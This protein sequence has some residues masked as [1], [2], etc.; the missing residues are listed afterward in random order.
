MDNARHL[1]PWMSLDAVNR[2]LKKLKD[3][4]TYGIIDEIIEKV[5]VESKLAVDEPSFT[6]SKETVRSRVKRNDKLTKS[7]KGPSPLLGDI[8]PFLVEICKQKARM[9]QP[10]GMTE[11]L[12]MANSIIDG[13]DHHER[14]VNFKKGLRLSGDG[15]E[16]LGT[17]SWR[18]FRKRNKGVRCR[19][20]RHASNKLQR[21]EHLPKEIEDV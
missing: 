4:V 19:Y 15:L 21:V 10:M 5:L 18:L 20:G 16:K 9:G 14:M 17:C 12:A 2:Q 8:E 13:T 6:I 7:S 11:G 3:I 1:Y